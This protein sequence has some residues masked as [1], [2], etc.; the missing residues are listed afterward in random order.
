MAYPANHKNLGK[1]K[2]DLTQALENIKNAQSMVW[3]P[4]MM[5]ELDIVDE[6]I[7]WR[8]PTDVFQRYLYRP[9]F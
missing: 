2:A 7:N 4:S 6:A 1:A 8:S 9:C 3:I 5:S